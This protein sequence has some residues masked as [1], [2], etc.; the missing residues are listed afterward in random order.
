VQGNQNTGTTA[1]GEARLAPEGGM[2]KDMCWNVQAEPFVPVRRGEVASEDKVGQSLKGVGDVGE[3]K[4]EEKRGEKKVESPHL[5]MVGRQ[6]SGHLG[7]PV[8][9]LFNRFQGL[10]VQELPGRNDQE[11]Q[12]GGLGEAG[13]KPRRRRRRAATQELEELQNEVPVGT[14]LW[15]EVAIEELSTR[16]YFD[17]GCGAEG[18]VD[19]DFL[20]ELEKQGVRIRIRPSGKRFVTADDQ[21]L[22]AVGLVNLRVSLA[23]GVCKRLEFVVVRKSGLG[24]SLGL[25]GIYKLDPDLLDPSRPGALSFP[26]SDGENRRAHLVSTNI[27]LYTVED[28]LIPPYAAL[29]TWVRA[30]GPEVEQRI[31][32]EALVAGYLG[33]EGDRPAVMASLT[34]V[35]ER[36]EGAG[37]LVGLSNPSGKERWIHKGTRVASLQVLGYN[38]SQTVQVANMLPEEVGPQEV[39][40]EDEERN[41]GQLS[42]QEEVPI[43][44]F[45]GD[46]QDLAELPASTPKWLKEEIQIHLREKKIPWTTQQ[47]EAFAELAAQL[48]GRLGHGGDELSEAQS[49]QLVR[50]LLRYEARFSPAKFNNAGGAT[51]T[52]VNLDTGKAAPR[53]RPPYRSALKHRELESKCVEQM[54]EQGVIRPS[55]SPWAAPVVI[56]TK[57]DG[58]PRFCVDYRGGLNKV[59]EK[60]AFPLPRVDE[61]LEKLGGANYL[62][63]LDCTSAYW[64]VKLDEESK[65]KTAFVTAHQQYEFNVLPFGVATAPA[66]MQRAMQEALAG[67][68]W[69]AVLVYLDD[70]LIF[71]RSFEEHLDHLGAVF[72]RLEAANLTL[73]LSKCKFCVSEV[74]YLGH[75]VGRGGI[76]VDPQKTRAIEEAR[77]PTSKKELRSF[78]GLA[79][80]YR[81]FVPNLAELAA[82]LTVL[83]GKNTRFAWGEVQ[84][85]AFEAVKRELAQTPVLA[86]PN[87]E[88][89]FRVRSDACGVAIG[90]VLEQQQE[91]GSWAPILFF[92][93]SLSS[94]ERNYGATER[95]ALAAVALIDHCRAYLV[96]NQ[97]VLETDA[98]ALKW[99]LARQGHNSRLSRWGLL[100]AEYD[101]E[102]VHR[103]G[104]EMTDADALSRPPFAPE[105][106]GEGFESLED[107]FD[108]WIAGEP[109]FGNLSDIRELQRVQDQAIRV[110]N[111]REVEVAQEAPTPIDVGQAQQGDPDLQALRKAIRGEPLSA[112]EKK[113]WSIRLKDDMGLVDDVLYFKGQ[114]GGQKGRLWRS[115]RVGEA[116]W[117]IVVP[118]SLR[119]TILRHLHCDPAAGHSGRNKTLRRVREKYYWP[120][121]ARDVKK[122]VRNCLA[123]ARAKAGAVDPGARNTLVASEPWE[124]VSTDVFGP[125]ERTELGNTHLVTFIDHFSRMAF[126]IPTRGA[127]ARDTAGALAQVITQVGF[128]RRLLSDRGQEFMA[129]VYQALA[130]D[131]KIHQVWTSGYS[132]QGNG[133]IE[134][135]HRSLRNALSHVVGPGQDDWD[136]WAPWAVFSYNTSVNEVTGETPF[137]LNYLRDA[138]HPFEAGLPNLDAL[139]QEDEEDGAGGTLTWR[140]E[141]AEKAAEVVKRTSKILEA[142]AEWLAQT[143]PSKQAPKFEVGDLVMVKYMRKDRGKFGRRYDG[144]ARVEAVWSGGVVARVAWLDGSGRKPSTMHIRRLKKYGGTVPAEERSSDAGSPGE[145][146]NTPSYVVDATTVEEDKGEELEGEVAEVEKVVNMRVN[147]VTEEHE[148]EVKWAGCT[149]AENEWLPLS[150]QSG[151]SRKVVDE[152]STGGDGGMGMWTGSDNPGF[153]S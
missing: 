33:L 67:L 32:A 83:T 71:S 125:L 9:P 128:P 39:E 150:Q 103:P 109:D 1:R 70:L 129:K 137:Y 6:K 61:S 112:E 26:T 100:L 64:Q 106:E 119:E 30:Q 87:L 114:E 36:S 126:A 127:T 59:L 66:L 60:V 123:C 58:S 94:A 93:R 53:S 133:R 88:R 113:S 76:K 146:A 124:L 38:R 42:R 55:K 41:T 12:V 139:A 19:L 134:R 104:R 130:K 138:R 135:F 8:V 24:A 37:C 2:I 80:F 45:S 10:P 144:P 65:P 140:T 69:Y 149:D 102:V 73:K 25:P 91:D 98:R 141:M 79:N 74:D 11:I 50:L 132:P 108:W 14:L 75:V 44:S 16:L 148:F 97:F 122:F 105:R 51:F 118:Q 116:S 86:Y 52:P 49:R 117:R 7:N 147:P 84:Q 145:A 120:R 92:S 77:A 22:R 121:M 72:E 17:T 54:L 29:N 21:E 28:L 47:R 35:S 13:R 143:N 81:R 151:S 62:T 111:L 5:H 3:E 110:A 89:P 131:W 4:Q 153:E 15:G 46:Q 136:V 115:N 31:G 142:Q 20:E 99:V 78:L 27:S 34:E 23:S 63:K 85:R 82:P 95:E 56:V 43:A 152:C 48:P 90:G 68:L 96:G 107:R 18:F 40:R 57:S 101:F